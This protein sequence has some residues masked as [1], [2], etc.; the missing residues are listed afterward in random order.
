[1]AKNKI[2]YNGNTLIDLTGDTVTADKLMQ[3]YTAHDRSGAVIT[4]TA[5]QGGSVTQDQ[6]GFIVLPPDGSGGGGGSGN[7]AEV[8]VY[9]TINGIPTEMDS[10]ELFVATSIVD[11]TTSASYT[12]PSNAFT[13]V[14]YQE[15][16]L[17]REFH[18][19]LEGG[20]YI[21]NYSVMP[22][23]TGDIGFDE[24]YNIVISGDG[25]ITFDM[26]ED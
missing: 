20:Y 23:F 7:I 14:L 12:L 10:Y 17:M 1:M 22:V 15:P 11:N 2:I 16:I 24:E 6:D 25:T 13:I 9:T 8:T 19:T 5:T 21:T 26:V 18:A 4:G 3:G